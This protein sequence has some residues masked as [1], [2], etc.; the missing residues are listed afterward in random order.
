MTWYY[1]RV[2][3]AIC[4]RVTLSH[5]NLV[6]KAYALYLVRASEGFRVEHSGSIQ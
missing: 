6:T 1:A 3:V 5:T 2:Y 4:I